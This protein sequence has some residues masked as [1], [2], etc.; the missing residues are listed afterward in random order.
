MCDLVHTVFYYKTSR[1]LRCFLSVSLLAILV[2]GGNDATATEISA[3]IAYK[4]TVYSDLPSITARLKQYSLRDDSIVQNSWVVLSPHGMHVSD[5]EGS[6]EVLKNFHTKRIWMIDRKR[7]LYYALEVEKYQQE[8]PA[9]A[10]NLFSQ[11]SAT[12]LMGQ[13][14]CEGWFGKLIGERIWRGQVVQEWHCTDE[15][16]VLVNKQYLSMDYGLV[17]RV[18]SANMA[19]DELTDIKTRAIT[20]TLRIR[21]LPVRIITQVFSKHSC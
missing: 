18:Q 10:T 21:C 20:L 1:R 6:S 9:L 13:T 12:N 7:K 5:A 14:A 16:Q 11:A 19:V 15:Q 3:P 4:S 8:Y 2:T 17:I